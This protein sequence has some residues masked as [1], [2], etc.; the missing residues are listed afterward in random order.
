MPIWSLAFENISDHRLAAKDNVWLRPTAEDQIGNWKSE[1]GNELFLGIVRR[2]DLDYIVDSVDD[3]E[4]IV[5]AHGG[6]VDP[7]NNREHEQDS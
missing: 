1:I 5:S 4:E 3:A 2:E 6:E 7:A